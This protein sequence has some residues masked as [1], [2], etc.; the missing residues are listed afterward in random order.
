MATAVIINS[1]LQFRQIAFKGVIGSEITASNIDDLLRSSFAGCHYNS[2]NSVIGFS[3]YRCLKRCGF[4][5][6]DNIPSLQND[7]SS[8]LRNSIQM[9]V[10]GADCVFL[11]MQDILRPDALSIWSDRDLEMLSFIAEQASGRLCIVSLGV[12]SISNAFASISEMMSSV[13]SEVMEIVSQL[14]E[15]SVICQVR[16][17]DLQDF[18]Q[19][20]HSRLYWLPAG[21]PSIFMKKLS[22]EV[23]ARNLI[24][25]QNW[26]ESAGLIAV[27]GLFGTRRPNLARQTLLIAQEAV[28]IQI[29]DR[30]Y[31]ESPS[32]NYP[33]FQPSLSSVVARREVYTFFHPGDWCNFI[34][35]QDPVVY[36]GTRLHGGIVCLSNSVPCVF[37]GGDSRT[38][39]F[40]ETFGLPHSPGAM[41]ED[42]K[43]IL[44]D[45]DYKASLAS[46]EHSR[47]G[48]LQGIAKLDK[49]IATSQS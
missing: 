48:F 30:L 4:T 27:G 20:R 9:A 7:D 35:D 12:N 19:R 26:H 23:M 33:Y 18:L 17:L 42:C 41:I 3:L 15:S 13:P 38:R 45:W 43:R 5:I 46:I 14:L 21:C 11:C 31:S 8:V 47:K 49:L 44:K 16:S 37:T 2:G 10:K 6:K 34:A 22:A 39:S 36:I 24:R 32:S 40:C 28:E 1:C 29:A 25:L